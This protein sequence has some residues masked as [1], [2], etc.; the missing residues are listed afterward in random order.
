LDLCSVGDELSREFFRIKR[1]QLGELTHN[2]GDMDRE[3]SYNSKYA[4]PCM[5]LVGTE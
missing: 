3:I 1:E 5:V 2:Q 4:K